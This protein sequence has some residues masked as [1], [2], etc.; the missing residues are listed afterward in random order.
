MCDARPGGEAGAESCSELEDDISGNTT[1]APVLIAGQYA[2]NKVVSC[3]SS[4][5]SWMRSPLRGGQ[6]STPAHL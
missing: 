3:T 1:S 6:D 5:P 4:L 2:R